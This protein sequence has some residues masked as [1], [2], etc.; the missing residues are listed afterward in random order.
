MT[1]RVLAPLPE[2]KELLRWDTLSGIL[3]RHDDGFHWRCPACGRSGTALRQ[4]PLGQTCDR[5]KTVK[6]V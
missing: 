1:G 5:R 4:P 3:I 2:C 6:R